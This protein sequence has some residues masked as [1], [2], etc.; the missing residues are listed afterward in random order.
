MK[1]GKRK[2][3]DI[4]DN[5][6]TALNII[7][8]NATSEAYKRAAANASVEITKISN[9]ELVGTRGG[10]SRVISRVGKPRKVLKGTKFD[11]DLEP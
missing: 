6:P 8:A 1:S 10:K 7:A 5:N 9:G 11:I 2:F 3:D 4:E